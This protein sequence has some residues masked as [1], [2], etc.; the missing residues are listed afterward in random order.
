MER[1][2]DVTVGDDVT[3]GLRVVRACCSGR[4]TGWRVITKNVITYE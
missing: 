1:V 3:L 2:Y 4:C